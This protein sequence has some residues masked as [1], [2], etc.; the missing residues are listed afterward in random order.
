MNIKSMNCPSCGNTLPTD[1]QANQLIKCAAC[2]N[3]LYLSDWEIGNTTTAVAVATPSHVY[4]VTDLLS[5]DDLCNVYRCTYKIEDK[6]WQGMFRIARDPA[7]N[8][9]VKNEA[10]TLYHLQSARDYDQFGLFLPSI[11]ESFS[12]QDASASG[13]RQVNICGLHKDIKKPNELY[14]FEEVREHYDSGIDPKDMAWMWRRLLYILGF[15]HSNEV[16]HGAIVPSHVLIEPKE[17]KLL[18]TGWGFSARKPNRMKA[19]SIRYESWYPPE[20]EDKKP[21]TP[22]FDLF[23]AARCMLY[24]VGAD[25]L[26]DLSFSR[27]NPALQKHFEK[28]LDENPRKRPQDAWAVLEEFDGIIEDLWGERQFREFSMPYKK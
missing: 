6:E 25:P 20:T 5:K 19:L 17:H 16:V 1:I 2:G 3:T 10:Q 11:L 27:L 9:L 24:L 13:T 4:T 23:L 21:P 12:Y 7:D 22:G 26:K 18:L 28:C 15:V 8:D 14:S